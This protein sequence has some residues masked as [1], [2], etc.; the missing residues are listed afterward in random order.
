MS[1]SLRPLTADEIAELAPKIE[2]AYAED[3]RQNGG[4]S[5]EV[6]RRKAADDTAKVLGDP[7][8]A[9]YALEHDGERVGHL[10]VGD[11][12]LQERCVLWIWD[13]F[14]DE[15]HRGRGHGRAA[16]QL[17]EEE[18]RRRG[19]QRIELNVFGGNEVARSLYRSLGYAEWA[20]AMGKDLA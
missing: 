15:A 13:V 16:M 12:Q 7:A 1:P 11:R 8:N 14:V 18:A 5:A 3:M 9:L 19:L 10:W 6:A 17:A 2:H 4:L 20:V